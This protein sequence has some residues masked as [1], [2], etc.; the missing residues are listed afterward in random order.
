MY[1]IYTIEQG[2]T[3]DI[4]AEKTGTTVDNLENINKTINIQ[5][6]KLIIVPA[7]NNEMF[8]VYTVKKGDSPYSVSEQYNMSVKD[9]LMMNGLEKG[10]YIYPGQQLIVPNMNMDVYITKSGDT[11]DKLVDNFKADLEDIYNQNSKIYLVPEQLIVYR[12]G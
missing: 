7:V 8:G 12:R 5:P 4:I 6:G 11:L 2:D 3:L 10:D 1:E 9:L